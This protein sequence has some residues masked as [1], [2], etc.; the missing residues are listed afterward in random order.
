[1]K[2]RIPQFLEEKDTIAIT[3]PSFGCTTEPYISK[4]NTAKKTIES[5]GYS[6]KTGDTVKKSDGLGISTKPGTCAEELVE[7]Y[8]DPSTKA[9]ISAGGGEMMCE[10]AGHIS[11]EKLASSAPKWFMGY[12]DNTNFIFPLV[13]IS[14]TAGIY[15]PCISGFGKK[16]EQ[17]ETDAFD[18]L[19]GKTNIVRGYGKFQRPEDDTN[20]EDGFEN[21]TYTLSAEKVL[22][23]FIPDMNTLSKVQDPRQIEMEGILLGGCLDVLANLCGTRLDKVME[24]M[25]YI[26]NQ[27]II[28]VLESCD[29]NPMELRRQVW[30]LKN[31]GW[32]RNTAGFLVGR[33]LASFEQEMMG[34]NQYNAVTD[35]LGDLGVPVIMDCDIGHIDPAMPLVMGACSKVKVFGNEITVEFRLS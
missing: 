28:W 22:S 12:S 25:D 15:G 30:H 26:G 33:P 6:I 10:T 8:T 29:A 21:Y 13:T 23:S 27:K 3:A 32:F 9:I 5:M 34:V 14:H 11:F 35:I 18:I 20:P 2:I 31:A 24:F 16:W 4:F 7:F 1:M 19:E 17:S